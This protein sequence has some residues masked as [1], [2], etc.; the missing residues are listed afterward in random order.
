MQLNLAVQ[1]LRKKYPLEKVLFNHSGM[2]IFPVMRNWIWMVTKKKSMYDY[3]YWNLDGFVKKMY[4]FDL[5]DNSSKDI[6]FKLP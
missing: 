5:A 3:L 4:P 2:P 1:V 6:Q